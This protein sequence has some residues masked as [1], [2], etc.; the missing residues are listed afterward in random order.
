M[1]AR[2]IARQLLQRFQHRAKASLR[3]LVYAAI[4]FFEA[5]FGAFAKVARYGDPQRR[6]KLAMPEER[7]SPARLERLG[8]AQEIVDHYVGRLQV[9][10]AR[11][12]SIDVAD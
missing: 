4:V 2:R 8:V 7:V 12:E 5:P 9:G 3:R 11:K 1:L 10:E 6:R